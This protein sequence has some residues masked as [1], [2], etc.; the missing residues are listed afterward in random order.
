MTKNIVL[1]TKDP[2]ISTFL[3]Q[4]SR[5]SVIESVDNFDALSETI[6][7]Y[8]PDAA[9]FVYDASENII[10]DAK[11]IRAKHPNT[12]LV[13]I[14]DDVSN[15]EFLKFGVKAFSEDDLI[16]AV[17]ELAADDETIGSGYSYGNATI[18]QR[19]IAFLGTADGVGVST[20][21]VCLARTYAD[22]GIPTVLIDANTRFPFHHLWSGNFNVD[23]SLVGMMPQID[24]ELLSEQSLKKHITRVAG[25][26]DLSVVNGF[27]SQ[28]ELFVKN[29]DPRFMET[30]LPI[31]KETFPVIIIDLS[32]DVTSGW[33]IAGLRRATE[34]F[35]VIKPDIQHLFQAE[36]L[37]NNM[38]G[39]FVR[40]GID[41]EK[42]LVLGRG[43]KEGYGDITPIA[44]IPDLGDDPQ[45]AVDAHQ[46][47]AVFKTQATKT[48]WVD[49]A[50]RTME[51][52]DLSK[53]KRSWF[54]L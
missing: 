25:I 49:I 40:F 38:E 28:P 53:K 48:F 9:L 16:L 12:K 39:F 5:V 31:L 19:V 47:P 37:L 11:L 4:D 7:Q 42:I 20:A 33:T 14:S 22:A 43:S 44:I 30:L 23:R 15:V 27:I 32:P 46:C 6:E 45:K 18:R 26:K 54:R 34:V 10:E 1:A 51:G 8:Q 29:N 2:V 3:N 36:R 17:E 13:V 52:I 50:R 41:K 24:S 21:A 35:F